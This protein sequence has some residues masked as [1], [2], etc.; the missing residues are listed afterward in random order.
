MMGGRG[1]IGSFLDAGAIDQSII[2]DVPVL[3]GDGI[4]LNRVHT[5]PFENL[6]RTRTTDRGS[7]GTMHR[8]RAGKMRRMKTL[9]DVRIVTTDVNIPGVVAAMLRVRGATG[10]KVEP[11]GGDLLSSFPMRTN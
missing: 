7:S 1:I 9:A 4:P 5:H 11:P 6:L 2:N 3:I 8:H 10:V